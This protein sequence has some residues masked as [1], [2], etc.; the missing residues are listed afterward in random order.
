MP[1]G[2]SEAGDAEPPIQGWQ[3]VA[4]WLRIAWM[5]EAVG[6]LL[7]L[8][9]AAQVK[10]GGLST[11][12]SGTISPGYSA[13]WG[14]ETGS[15]HS[16]MFGG[17]GNFSG[18][19]YNPNFLSFD[20][21]FYLDQSRANSNFQS[22]SNASGVTVNSNIFGGSHF[23][24]SINYSTAWNSEGN[25]NVPGLANYVTHGDSNTFGIN[26][27]ENLPKAP[28]FS[29][30]LQRGS[31]SYSVYGTNEE[32]TN[33]F[34]SLNLHSGYKL[35][36]FN[37]GAFYSTG[38]AHALIPE[39]ITNAPGTE[40][41]SSDDAL[42]VNVTHV[43]PFQGSVTA[44]FNRSEWSSDY[45]GSSSS[46][47]VDLTNAVA[48]VHPSQKV[49]VT[50]TVDYSDNLTG[51][52]LGAVVAAGG[53]VA[54]ANSNESSNSLDLLG[55]VTWQPLQHLETS[56]SVERL[57][58]NFLGENY[59]VTTY[60]GSVTYLRDVLDGTFNGALT[61]T[62]NVNDTSGENTLGFS[63]NGN[64]STVLM[65]WHLNGSFG[66]AQ[67]VQ[68]LLVTYMNSYYN[69]AF[70]ARRRW[71]RLSATAGAG[72]SRT[73][74]TQQTG[75]ESSSESYNASLGY[76]MWVTA[77]G[78]YAKA[79]GQALATGAGLVTVPI[80]PPVLPSSLV[81]LYGGN[82]YSF[83]LASTPV[84]KL[85]LSASYA[86]ST[87]NISSNGLTSNNQNNEFNTFI[88]YQTRKLY[89]T[90]GYARLEQGFSGSGVPP[91]VVSTF[92]IGV[93][94]WFNVF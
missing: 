39:V 88:Q 32:G 30:G 36:G 31:S 19:Y 69:Y 10:I 62:E 79:S 83:G 57:S 60:G 29:A 48:M 71:G 45:L 77:T 73:A 16:W 89:F 93:S 20:A 47:T 33:A 58:Q 90:S 17:A 51:Q 70:N 42:G 86:K 66:Y 81:S 82:S 13:D 23:P 61:V 87:S 74:L 44:G 75:V 21:S 25:Y 63:A 12:L 26:W 2:K 78:S 3:T 54:G 7:A 40:S 46:G 27:S 72:A 53:V 38:T 6:L 84:R 4:G 35:A 9:A 5:A 80:P 18:F 22:I 11:H 49:S 24:G 43:L 67:N 1:G 15:D 50:V 85:I 52:L 41:H 94:R 76:G 8:P 65:G 56:A 55:L 91:G 68:T 59:G 92:S 28:S 34:D 37:L 14:N 64:Y